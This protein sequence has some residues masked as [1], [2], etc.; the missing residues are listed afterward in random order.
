[1][2]IVWY[3]LWCALMLLRPL[4]TLLTLL[5]L[6]SMFCTYIDILTSTY[7]TYAT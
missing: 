3:A 4:L 6:L 1:M 7:F 5:S 2:V